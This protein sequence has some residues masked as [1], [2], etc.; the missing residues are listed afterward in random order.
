MVH[1]N[2]TAPV[3]PVSN[4]PHQ[5]AFALVGGMKDGCGLYGVHMTQYHCEVHKYQLILKLSVQPHVAKKLNE[6]RAAAPRDCFTLCNAKEGPDHPG[7]QEFTVP[8]LACG[9]RTEFVGNIFQGMR[10]FPS[11]MDEHFFP[12][13]EK[14]CRPALAE[15]TVNVERVVMFRPFAHHEIQPNYPTYYVWGDAKYGDDGAIIGEAHMTNLQTARLASGAFEPP[16]WGPDYDHIMSLLEPPQWLDPGLLRAGSVVSVPAIKL[17]HEGGIP[18]GDPFGVGN[19]VTTLYRGM[20]PPYSVVA[21]PT[22]FSATAVCNSPEADPY[23]G[24]NL[25]ISEMPREYWT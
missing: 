11:E 1:M 8:E 21:G 14:Y 2:P 16:V 20:G 23:K 5:H 15:V 18:A 6:L 4:H 9:D 19:P 12:W 25:F 13:A 22:F 3:A 10:P 17:K 7:I 24:K